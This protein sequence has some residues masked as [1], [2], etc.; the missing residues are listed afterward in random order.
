MAKIKITKE[1]IET[2]EAKTDL[3]YEILERAVKTPQSMLISSAESLYSYDVEKYLLTIK[4]RATENIRHLK[5]GGD[6]AK[7]LE[8]YILQCVLMNHVS[9][10]LGKEPEMPVQENLNDDMGSL[11]SLIDSEDSKKGYSKV[12]RLIQNKAAELRKEGKYDLILNAL[13]YV[14]DNYPKSNFD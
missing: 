13:K 7:V 14:R 4:G 6:R 11:K 1:D 9:L 3:A 10:T 2:L 12:F 8:R 5:K